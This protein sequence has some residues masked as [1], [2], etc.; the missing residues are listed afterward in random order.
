MTTRLTGANVLRMTARVRRIGAFLITAL[1]L[2]LAASPPDRAEAH[3]IKYGKAKRVA[4]QRADRIAGQ[5]TTVKS[6]FCFLDHQCSGSAEWSYVDPV[7]CKGCGYNP[8]TNSFY[9]TPITV[10]CFVNLKIK[11]QSA[12]S[13]RIVVAVTG[14]ACI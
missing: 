2:L 3:T 7:G 11:F 13:N 1:G 14:Q 10:Q 12:R 6:L 8:V 5:G 9:D 4:Q